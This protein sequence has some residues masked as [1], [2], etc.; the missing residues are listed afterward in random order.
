MKE[1][2]SRLL[3]GSKVIKRLRDAMIVYSF[4]PILFMAVSFFVY[5]QFTGLTSERYACYA[6]TALCSILMAF[7][8]SLMIDKRLQLGY[9][10]QCGLG[11]SAAALML[12]I[13]VWW[14]NM[15]PNYALLAVVFYVLG[16]AAFV[17]GLNVNVPLK[18]VNIVFYC[19]ILVSGLIGWDT[20]TVVAVVAM[21]IVAYPMIVSYL[22]VRWASSEFFK[23]SER[24]K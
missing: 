8:I 18:A 19:V 3:S 11:V 15:S 2:A 22:A 9:V 17:V 23:L 14:M 1:D 16:Q 10:A 21:S 13:G 6:M 4:V 24:D 5:M 20:Q 12:G 7:T